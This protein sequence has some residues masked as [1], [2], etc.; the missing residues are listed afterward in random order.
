MVRLVFRPFPEYNDRSERQY[1]HEP[2]PVFA[3]LKPRSTSFKSLIKPLS[4]SRNIDTYIDIDIDIEIDI[5]IDIDTD[6]DVYIYI[7]IYIYIYVQMYLFFLKT[8]VLS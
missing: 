3:L 6:I 1:R 7:Y 4:R 5:D 8:Y 2:P